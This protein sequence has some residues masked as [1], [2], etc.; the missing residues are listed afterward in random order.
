MEPS[1]GVSASCAYL[2]PSCG[3][4]FL[5]AKS[6]NRG[7]TGDGVTILECGRKDRLRWNCEEGLCLHMPMD[8]DGCCYNGWSL[9]SDQ[10]GN[11]EKNEEDDEEDDEDEEDEGSEGNEDDE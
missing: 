4:Q 3:H 9:E 10:E 11:E 2:T 6:W 5:E 1:T 8:E 7:W